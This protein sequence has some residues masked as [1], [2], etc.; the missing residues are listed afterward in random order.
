MDA[1]SDLKVVGFWLREEHRWSEPMIKV[2][3]NPHDVQA[4]LGLVLPYQ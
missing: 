1:L 3:F 2:I 4:I